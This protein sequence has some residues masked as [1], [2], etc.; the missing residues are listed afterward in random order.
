MSE[1]CPWRADTTEPNCGDRNSCL[2]GLNKVKAA[3]ARG[4][5]SGEGMQFGGGGDGLLGVSLEDMP[6]V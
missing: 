6:F 5:W 3:Y 1:L 4:T 2:L